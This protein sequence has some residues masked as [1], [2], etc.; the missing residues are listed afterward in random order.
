MRIATTSVL[1]GVFVLALAVCRAAA[2]DPLDDDHHAIAQAMADEAIAYLRSQ[3]DK[4]TGGWS[5]PDEGPAL[6]GVTAMALTGL[7]MHPD[8]DEQDEAVA[9]G[10]AYLLSFRQED[11]GIY[12]RILPNYNTALSV[13]ALARVP[14]P[15]A[16]QAVKDGQAFLRSL[17]WDGQTDAAGNPI[18]AS[19]AFYGGAGYGSHSRPDGSNLNVM[20]QAMHD[21][22]VD[23]ND[24]SYVR[25][26][27]FLE[28]LQMLDDVNDMPYARGSKQGGFIYATSPSG[29]EIGAG[30][31]KAG[32]IEET[33][34]DGTVISRLRS[35][36]SMTYAG[37]KSYVYANL[38]RDDPR[39]VAAYEW[40]RRHYVL[41]ENPGLGMQGY[42]YYLVTFSRSLDAWGEEMITPVLADGSSGEPRR[43]ANDLVDTLAALQREDGSFVNEVDR[44]MEGDP[45]LTTSYALLAL[46]EVL[47]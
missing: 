12:D 37:F 22:G 25:A 1:L 23:C 42:F 32:T 16:A 3:Q 2:L 34:D 33:L 24:E 15:E 6:P 10:V 36:G 14:T 31:S 43:W 13:S 38:D 8:I 39:V 21:S 4:A 27:A 11:G 40:I 30:E 45:V 20:I 18:D 7:L 41:T 29:D 44:W 9:R 28:R 19:H 47:E 46:Q 17:Q 26:V 35:Y 5:I